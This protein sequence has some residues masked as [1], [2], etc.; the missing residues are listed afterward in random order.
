MRDR[1]LTTER[2]SRQRIAE[3]EKDLRHSEDLLSQQ[4]PSFDSVGLA[5]DLPLSAKYNTACVKLDSAEGQISDLKQQLDN[6]LG[7]EEMLEQLTERTLFMGEV[8][9]PDTRLL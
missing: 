5:A 9:M 6:A 2:E 3:L 7:A 8:R 4:D 1:L